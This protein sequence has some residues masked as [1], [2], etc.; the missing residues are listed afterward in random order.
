MREWALRIDECCGGSL[1]VGCVT[2]AY[3][4]SEAFSPE[5]EWGLV[6]V[7]GEAY[8]LRHTA[9]LIGSS[10][11]VWECSEKGPRSLTALVKEQIGDVVESG[12]LQISDGLRS[13]VVETSQ[14]LSF[15]T[16]GSTIIMKLDTEERTLSFAVNQS[17]PFVLTGV[18]PEVRPVVAL[19]AVGDSVT[20]IDPRCVA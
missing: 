5:S 4:A 2:N 18:A 7:L 16:P 9:Y 8:N 20:L 6:G 3:K 14:A 1:H 15:M 13:F 10:G 12:Q 19:K 17:P 11:Q